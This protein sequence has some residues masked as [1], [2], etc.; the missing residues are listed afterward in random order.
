[1]EIITE[2]SNIIQAVGFP[3]VMCLLF[4]WYIKEQRESH[5][6]EVNNLTSKFTD[7]LSEMNKILSEIATKFDLIIN[8]GNENEN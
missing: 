7:C 5:K 6:E 2:I 4:F 8:G 3:I 1:M